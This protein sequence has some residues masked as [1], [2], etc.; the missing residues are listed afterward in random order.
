MSSDDEPIATRARRRRLY[1]ISDM[2]AYPR[3]QGADAI[4][5][6]FSSSDGDDRSSDWPQTTEATSKPTS[7]QVPTTQSVGGGL[8]EDRWPDAEIE[9]EPSGLE[10]EASM[11]DN[12]SRPDVS[13]HSEMSTPASTFTGFLNDT[14][15]SDTKP[16]SPVAPSSA[17]TATSDEEFQ[18]WYEPQ[19]RVHLNVS[20]TA[21]PD[22]DV[23][24]PN[25]DNEPRLD[26]VP[27]AA[28]VPEVTVDAPATAEE[29]Q[30]R[31]CLGGDEEQA[32]LGRL[33]R[34][35]RCRGSMKYV[36]V[37]CLNEWRKA[38]QSSTSYWACDQCKYKYN[39]A[40]TN[41]VLVTS[42]DLD[43]STSASY[44]DK[45]STRENTESTL[46]YYWSYSSAYNAASD[47]ISLAVHTL[48]DAV[49]YQDGYVDQNNDD[50]GNLYYETWKKWTTPSEK[51]SK[52]SAKVRERAKTADRYIKARARKQSSTTRSR[53]PDKRERL[54][55]DEEES[56]AAE[57]PPLVE[58][59]VSL[60]YRLAQR[61]I[62]G[63]SFLG[64][65]SFLN[66]LLS[67]SFYAP[68]QLMRRGRGLFGG[69]RVHGDRATGGGFDIGTALVVLFVAIGVARAIYKI[70]QFNRFLARKVLARAETAILEVGEDDQGD[71][72]DGTLRDQGWSAPWRRP[73][74]T[75]NS[76]ARKFYDIFGDPL[77]PFYLK[78]VRNFMRLVSWSIGGAIRMW[79][80]FGAVR[81]I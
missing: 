53:H 47:I 59:Y 45:V 20:G 2:G 56:A 79:Q 18:P 37:S 35:C 15:S 40:R 58:G 19:P 61:F 23:T 74:E 30:C 27:S 33:F 62:I 8:E 1:S 16:P 71:G 36:H 26:V 64:I 29:I 69:R 22:P 10:P 39:L 73:W 72:G 42:P 60:P 21:G 24:T 70:Y 14:S 38:A 52:G 9:I 13:L 31:I 48:N 50:A 44:L 49:F 51:S 25:V 34:P 43:P 12:N 76:W 41:A 78:V 17:C 3:Q 66:L 68:A 32:E 57:W 67:L 81:E 6:D 65:V 80:D 46:E 4:D 7:S 63:L 77:E 54:R 11:S 5:M 55:E 28:P 75:L